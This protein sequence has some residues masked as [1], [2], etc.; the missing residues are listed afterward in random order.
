MSLKT[1]PLTWALGEEILDFDVRA[2]HSKETIAELR[3]L[4][5]ERGVLLFRNQDISIQEHIKFTDYFG[6]QPFFPALQRNLHPEDP[7][8][9]IVTNIKSDDGTESYTRN[10]G[11]IWHSDQSFMPEPC[12]GSLLHAKELPKVGGNTMFAN[13]YKAYDELSDGMKKM[14]EG[15]RALHDLNQ[16]SVYKERPPRTAEE[17]AQTPARYQPI[18]RTHPETGRK[19]I[20]VHPDVVTQIEGMTVEESQPILAHLAAQVSKEEN[21][22]RHKWAINDLL[23]WDNRCV[24]HYAPLDYDQSDRSNRRKMYRTTIEGSAAY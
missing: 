2:D 5:C 13:A 17:E 3:K 22:Y 11:R 18:F 8:I 15:K 14:F 7:R 20:F 23:F 12:M 9:W 19:L 21:T 10:T 4:V 1:K 16:A 6:E 24:Q